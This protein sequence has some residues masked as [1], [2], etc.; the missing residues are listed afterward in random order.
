MPGKGRCVKIIICPAPP[1]QPFF[2][3]AATLGAVGL[4]IV[5][6]SVCTCHL[7]LV[8]I[9]TCVTC[10]VLCGHLDILTFVSVN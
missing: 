2:L 1:A 7:A 8:V 6:F 4:G 5:K 3:P 9:D 10:M